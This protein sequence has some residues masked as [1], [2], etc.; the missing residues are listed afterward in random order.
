VVF[1]EEQV[2]Q[3]VIEMMLEPIKI[4]P[5]PDCNGDVEWDGIPWGEIR[6]SHPELPEVP[7]RDCV[8]L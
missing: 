5:Y 4:C 2:E 8:Y 3:D 1:R 7:E 6:K